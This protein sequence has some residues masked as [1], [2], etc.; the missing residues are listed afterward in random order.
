MLYNLL[1][2]QSQVKDKILLPQLP[3]HRHRKL[4]LGSRD[5]KRLQMIDTMKAVIIQ[6]GKSAGYD[7]IENYDLGVGPIYVTWIFKPG[8]TESLPDMRLGFVCRVFSI[9]I[10]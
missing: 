4:L 7:V 2:S 9:F 3:P 8:G 10:K 5:H 6:T 1:L